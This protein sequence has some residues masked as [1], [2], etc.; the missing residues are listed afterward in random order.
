M[1][2][3][4]QWSSV[5]S[6]QHWWGHCFFL[7]LSGLSEVRERQ[8]CSVPWTDIGVNRDVHTWRTG[9]LLFVTCCF[10][11]NFFH[12]LKVSKVILNHTSVLPK[13]NWSNF[14]TMLSIMLYSNWLPWKFI[15]LFRFCQICPPTQLHL[16][17]MCT[18]VCVCLFFSWV[19]FSRMSASNNEE[20]DY[21]DRSSG[22][23]WLEG[24]C[25]SQSNHANFT[26]KLMFSWRQA[27]KSAVLYKPI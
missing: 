7:L 26:F 8:S 19:M 9:R 16:P 27:K 5:S 13:W 24:A 11:N 25:P 23:L 2:L 4:N 12:P 6:K 18:C 15:V 10:S 14:I 22:M 1:A 21:F 3:Y 17:S 20:R